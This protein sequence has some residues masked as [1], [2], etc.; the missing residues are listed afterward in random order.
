M[1]PRDG[2]RQQWITRRINCDAVIGER[3]MGA[4][5]YARHVARYARPGYRLTMRFV[6]VAGLA[7]R[8]IRRGVPIQLPVRR[9]AREAIQAAVAAEE[10]PAGGQAQGLI[11]SVARVAQV[12]EFFAAFGIGPVAL[13]AKAIHSHGGQLGGSAQLVVRGIADVGGGRAMTDFAAH[14]EFVR[15]HLIVFA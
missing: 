7:V 13:A 4:I 9:M 5:G 15:E 6:R 10:A 8:I 2:N 14:A 11:A 1:R 3:E 12:R